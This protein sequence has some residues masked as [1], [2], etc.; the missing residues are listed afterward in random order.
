MFIAH[1]ENTSKQIRT[2]Q[3]RLAQYRFCVKY[4][5]RIFQQKTK[6]PNKQ[7]KA[8]RT[9]SKSFYFNL[10]IAKLNEGLTFKNKTK[11]K[12]SLC[13]FGLIYN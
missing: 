9:T 6:L 12:D 1:L 2:L 7:A 5:C 8:K 11:Q 4:L 10:Y 3:Y 13:L